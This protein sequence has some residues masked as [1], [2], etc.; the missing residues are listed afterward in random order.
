[1]KKNFVRL[2]ALVLCM[3]IAAGTGAMNVQAAESSACYKTTVKK[4]ASAKET[5]RRM[6]ELAKEYGVEV[7]DGQYDNDIIFEAICEAIERYDEKL[8]I[9]QGKNDII[10]NNWYQFLAAS[11]FKYFYLTKVY[12][13]THD[14][15]VVFTFNYCADAAQIER[16]IAEIDSVYRNIEYDLMNQNLDGSEWKTAKYVY[17]YLAKTVVYDDTVSGA[18]IR[19]IY[20]ALVE[21]KAVCAGYAMAFDY[22]MSR[23]GYKVGVA[24]NADHVWNYIHWD[25]DGRFLDATWGD[26]DSYD[27]YGWEY[28]DYTYFS[29]TYEEL[30]NLEEHRIDYIYISGRGYDNSI[31]GSN[32]YLDGASVTDYCK[33]QGYDAGS[34]SYDIVREI[35]RIQCDLND[36]SII[37]KFD[38]NAALMAAVNAL[39][40]NNCAGLNEILTSIG[41]Y[42]VYRYTYNEAC[43]TIV[44]YLNAQ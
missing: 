36:N 12:C 23:L 30:Q 16:M 22:I 8:V 3:I 27:S 2:V 34:Y 1:M 40:A 5:E 31:V 20:G 19:N 25:S 14:D 24:G 11:D 38:D 33:V 37:I 44:I 35:V 41:Y 29:M 13:E 4:V 6:R 39:F 21:G 28:L 7:I 42:G 26:R 43:N 10:K 15:Y 9:Y 18:N 32:E 17:E